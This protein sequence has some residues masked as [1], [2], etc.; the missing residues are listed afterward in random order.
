MLLGKQLSEWVSWMSKL[1]AN[2]GQ[3]YNVILGQS[4]TFTR[5]KLKSLKGWDAML[6]SSD[7]IALMRGI[8]GI[9][10]QHKDTE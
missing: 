1:L 10:F 6:E 4:M 2:M 5:S 9:I 7:L 3:V 8:K